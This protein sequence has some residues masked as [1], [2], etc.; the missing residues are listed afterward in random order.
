M[1]DLAEKG[2][3]SEGTMGKTSEP[4]IIQKQMG[5]YLA[6]DIDVNKSMG[7]ERTCH[8]HHLNIP[9]HF[10]IQWKEFLTLLLG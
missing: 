6:I 7:W 8:M 3:E 2:R 5:K 10:E 1:L 4:E 9:G